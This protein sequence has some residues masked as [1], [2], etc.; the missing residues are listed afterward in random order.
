MHFQLQMQ[1]CFRE[2]LYISVLIWIDDVVLFAKGP[3]DYLEALRQFFELLRSRRLKPNMRRCNLFAHKVI[4]CGRPNDGTGIQH[5]LERLKC[6]N[7][8]RNH[9]TGLLCKITYV[10]SIDLEIP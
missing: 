2:M 6:C 7:T 4:C 9:Q 1:K 10:L 8:C 3:D 5:S